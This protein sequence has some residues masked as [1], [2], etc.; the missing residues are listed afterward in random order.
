MFI[1]LGECRKNY[2]Q[3][4]NTLNIFL[5]VKENCTWHLNSYWNVLLPMV[6]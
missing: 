2:R 5:I 4:A 3:A 6:L 1:V